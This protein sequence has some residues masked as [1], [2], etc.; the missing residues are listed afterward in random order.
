MSQSYVLILTKPVVLVLV[1]II[2]QEMPR[3]L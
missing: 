1:V 2:R 3:A